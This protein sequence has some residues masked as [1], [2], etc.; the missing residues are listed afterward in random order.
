MAV[1]A[2]GDSLL[3]HTWTE[4]K[5][6]WDFIT[7]IVRHA[8]LVL[9]PDHLHALLPDASQRPPLARALRAFA[10]WRNARRGQRGPVFAHRSQF[11]PIQ[12]AQHLERARRYVHLNPCRN[13]LVKDPLAWPFS[14]HRDAVGLVFPPVLRPVPNPARFHAY[15]SGDPSA[16]PAGTPLPRVGTLD[17]A[18]KFTVE[19]LRAAVSA[20]TRTLDEELSRRGAARTLLID[21]ALQLANV[22]GKELADALDVD[23]TTLRRHVRRYRRVGGDSRVTL[24]ATIADDKRFPLLTDADLRDTPEWRAY[25]NRP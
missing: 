23:V 2:A 11:R 24:V 5:A 18:R 15:V 25:R 3:F 6:L 22:Q 4:A 20:A 1:H 17:A 14:T 8:G 13:E 19:A 21:A 16:S 9:M 10:Q 12:N 7:A